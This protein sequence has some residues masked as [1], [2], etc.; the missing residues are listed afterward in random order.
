[1]TELS[2]VDLITPFITCQFLTMSN[3]IKRPD[4]TTPHLE[5]VG[6]IDAIM[7]FLLEN[8]DP[9]DKTAFQKAQRVSARLNSLIALF[10]KGEVKEGVDVSV[11]SFVH[12]IDA[13][14]KGYFEHRPNEK[15]KFSN[16]AKSIIDWL[17]DAS[18]DDL[19]SQE[20]QDE[21]I[22]S[23]SDVSTL[24]STKRALGEVL[25]DVDGQVRLKE[26][27][28]L[29][30]RERLVEKTRETIPQESRTA[31]ETALKSGRPFEDDAMRVGLLQDGGNTFIRHPDG[32]V[33]L[34]GDGLKRMIT[35]ILLNGSRAKEGY[36]DNPSHSSCEAQD[37]A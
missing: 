1:M 12:R 4:D 32:K 24:D 28:L 23:F 7:E 36:T 10:E 13:K 31:V 16:G 20:L 14:K 30:I 18:G 3:K 9:S 2:K 17:S 37:L 19:P 29:A 8:C 26:E 11:H 27:A 34:S 25:E 22:K 35:E 6:K 15:V 21:A 33:A 5:Q